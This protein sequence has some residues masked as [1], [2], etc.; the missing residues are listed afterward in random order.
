VGCSLIISNGAVA[1]CRIATLGYAT[2][3]SGNEFTL[4]GAG[5]ILRSGLNTIIGRD[6]PLN[7]MT[8]SDGASFTCATGM[9]GLNS[10]GFSNEV[11]VVGAGSAW[12]NRFDC[13]LGNSS[14][15]NRLA[16][17][18][19]ALVI[20]SNNLFMGVNAG[21]TNNLLTVDGG[22]LQVKNVP[23]TGL[24]DL[25]RGKV[26]FNNGA[27]ELDRLQ[28]LNSAGAFEF[29]GGTLSVE[30]SYINIGTTFFVGN[31]TNAATLILAGS[32]SHVFTIPPFVAANAT[33]T[34]NGSI[35]GVVILAGGSTFKPGASIGKITFTNSPVL[36]GNTI[37]EISRSGLSFTNDQVQVLAPVNYG[38]STLV[39]TNV[40]PDAPVSGNSFKL[41]DAT[42]YS[43]SFGSIT[44][45]EL[46][47]GLSW[48][49]KLLVDGT[50]EVI[51]QPSQPVFAGLTV[52]GTNLLLTGMNGTPGLD[53]AVL[54]ATNVT[55]FSS[56]WVSLFT[57]QFGA[58]GQFSFTNGINPNERQRYF[59]IRTP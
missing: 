58:G 34:G 11:T 12:T 26:V 4:T 30:N 39:V 48:T 9:L 2:S 24:L 42:S 52:S 49:N 51:G 27:M 47:P 23:G 19:G 25:H 14:A 41:F 28:I 59:R 45:P 32:G 22:T 37:M 35:G 50:I 29:N 10:S 31:V 40:G 53:Y 18:N 1:D 36:S 6:G 8:I 16:I 33:L 46:A 56:N 15:G 20:V 54:T 13:Y 17:T 44:L 5:S 3:S 38:G 57:N 55:E 21:S 7:R 43:G